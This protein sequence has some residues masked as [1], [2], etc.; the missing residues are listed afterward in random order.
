MATLKR[1]YD[2]DLDSLIRQQKQ[3]VEKAE[4]QQELDIKITSKRTRQEQERELKSFRETLKS[5]QKWLKTEI[6]RTVSK[7]KRKDVYRVQ[8]EQLDRKQAEK[9]KKFI[10]SLKKS[11]DNITNRLN[12]SHRDK[13]RL[14][15]RQYLQ[16]KHQLKRGREA[17]IWE[18][19]EKHIF[20]KYQLLKKQL[21]DSFFLQRHQMIVRHEKV[22]FLSQVSKISNSLNQDLERAKKMNNFQEEELLK[23]QAMEKRSLP[24]RIRS[25]M[26]TRELMFRESLR[27]SM[28]NLAN[29]D[30]DRDRLKRFQESEKQRYKAE[31]ERQDEKH[32]KQMEKL[33]S[34]CAAFI[35]DME[36]I[37]KDKKKALT[38]HETVKIK[39]LEEEHLEELRLW[40]GNLKPRKQVGFW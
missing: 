12:Q 30:E 17:A 26:K 4:Q 29:M 13:L 31:Q 16:Q 18:L 33:K 28:A 9:D 7:D 34:H 24:K 5:E 40:K 14:L 37:Q 8:K 35:R 11:Y 10:E 36:Q 32:R 39:L 19:E 27:I 38:E 22:S 15:E 6:D 3:Y 25:E 23:K 2:N 1:T 21:N 20:E